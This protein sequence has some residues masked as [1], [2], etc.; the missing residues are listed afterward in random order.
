M[1]SHPVVHP[2]R[3]ALALSLLAA[4]AACNAEVVEFGAA[5]SLPKDQR[6]TVWDAPPKARLGLPDIG[7]ANSSELQSGKQVISVPPTGWEQ[8]EAKGQFRD[9]AW[10][11]T[12][13]P[14]TDCYLTLGVGGGVAMNLNRWYVNQFGQSGAPAMESLPIVELGQRPARLA[15]IEGTFTGKDGWMALI[16]FYNR[17]QQVTSLK[18]TGPAAV[19]RANK[20]KF[21]ELAKSIRTASVSKDPSAPVI[22]PGDQMPAGH[23]DVGGG[24]G[25]TGAGA[26]NPNA[27]ASHNA[28]GDASLQADVP[29]G[30]Q[31]V[32]G[33]GKPLHY[34]FGSKG[35]VYVS[36]VG[37]SVKASCDIW[38]GEMT[39]QGQQF[40]PLTKDEFEALEKISFLGGEGVVMEVA[41]DYRG[42]VGE[43]IANARLLVAARGEGSSIVF[44]KMLG[45]A[46]EVAA[47][48]D[49]FVR[50]C[51][52]VRKP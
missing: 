44:C 17:G 45:P 10:R 1:N 14:E 3:R 29:D 31:P 12:G 8:V 6:P 34:S 32:Q 52:S 50:F 28:G 23:P 4:L 51:Q 38:R 42:M 18:F 48:R 33:S 22:E 11:V 21:L 47:Q 35:Q 15:E 41:G 27:P 49:A 5:R 30:W 40:G 7:P 37:G 43:P 39:S 24:A 20:Q 16:A 2:P 13:Q 26:P 9:A 36:M 46:G 19:V 25:M